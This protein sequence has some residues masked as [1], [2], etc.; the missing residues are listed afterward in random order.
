ML[1]LIVVVGAWVFLAAYTAWFLSSVK[2]RERERAKFYERFVGIYNS[3]KDAIG[4]VSLDGVLLDVNDSFCRLT[5]CSRE[6][7]LDNKKYQDLA[8]K[9]YH[10][11]E[12]K[13][14][15]RILRTGKP[16]EY[17]QEYIRKDGSRVPVLLTVFVAKGINGKILGI[18]AIIKDITERK[19][20]ERAIRD[21]REYAENIVATL[22]E[23]FVVLDRDLKVITGNRSFY[24]TFEMTPEEIEGRYIYEI[25]N[26]EWDIPQLRQLLEDILPRNI[27]FSDFEVEYDFQRIGRRVMLLNARRICK[28]ANITQMILLVIEDITEKKL[29]Q[30]RLITSEKLSTIGLLASVVGHEIRNPLGVIRNSACFL[31][32]KLKDNTDE[33]VVKHLKILEREVNSANLIISDLLDFARKKLPALELTDLNNVVMDVL[34]SI[35]IPE[36]IKVTTELCEIPPMLFDR[37]QIRRAFLNLT[38]NAVQAMPEGGK[39]LVQTSKHFD[40]VEIAFTDTGVGISKENMEKLFTPLFSTKAKG[41]GL[42]LSICKQ[43]VDG[44][45]GNITVQGSV[46]EGSTF[47]VKLPMLTKKT[48]DEKSAF[49]A[50]LTV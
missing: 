9:E 33:K 29:L 35:F 15:E 43:I 18:A 5:G 26:R 24:K 17:E 41:I 16:E 22:R 28:E 19:N 20:N 32:M 23:P 42:G 7:L 14:I 46:G 13:T 10:E 50:A 30:E 48:V 11:Y 36:N 12:A 34:S 1:E 6:E 37:E 38:L 25:G 3:S 47:T 8:P 44:H 45:D 31:S 39:L 2:K 4:Y 40:S 49:A 27:S 21:T